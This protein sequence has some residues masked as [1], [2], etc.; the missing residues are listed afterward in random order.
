MSR[1]RLGLYIFARTKL[2]KS[3]FELTPVFNKL[4][5]RPQTLALVTE[6][7][8][9]TKRSLDDKV[10]KPVEIADMPQMAQ[11]VFEFYQAKL[12]CWNK[13]QNVTKEVEDKGKSV[14]KVNANKERLK[15]L[16]EEEKVLREKLGKTLI[17]SNF[18]LI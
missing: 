10:E 16:D 17:L 7:Q 4:L 6:E 3:C 12:K 5:E 14:D 18:I 11:Y 2:F 9:P 15:K 1:A 13:L 8:Y